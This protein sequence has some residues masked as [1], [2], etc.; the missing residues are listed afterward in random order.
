MVVWV[1]ASSAILSEVAPILLRP[2]VEEVVVENAIVGEPNVE[3]VVVEN[4]MLGDG[5]PP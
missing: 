3:E 4:A 1:S 2:N 5:A